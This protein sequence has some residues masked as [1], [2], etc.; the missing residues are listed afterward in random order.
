MLATKPSDLTLAPQK[1]TEGFT[2]IIDRSTDTDIIDIRQLIFPVLMKKKYNELTLTH[3]HSGVILPTDRYEH[4]Y[5]MGAYSI[6]LVIELYDDTIE[7]DATR[8][9]VHKDEGKYEARRNDRALYKTVDTACK[10]FIM[11]VVDGTWYTE[12]EDPYTFYTNFTSLKILD[13]LT[14]FFSGLHKVDA[15]DIPQIMKTLFTDADGIPQFINAMGVAQR[16]S[17]RAKLVIQDEYMHVVALK[18]LLQ[19]GE[20]ETETR[21]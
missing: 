8:T 17:K 12:L 2:A 9:E 21:E 4:I 11:E 13:H 5:L 14:K 20:Y 7:K 1:V 15:V 18:L 6:P 3:N 19:S 10:N 16:K